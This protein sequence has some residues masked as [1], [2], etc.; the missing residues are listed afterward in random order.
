MWS[1]GCMPRKRKQN[2]QPCPWCAKRGLETIVRKARVTALERH[3]VK[4][5]AAYLMEQ[6]M[7][8]SDIPSREVLWQMVLSQGREVADLKA[9]VARLETKR[10][11]RAKKHISPRECWNRRKRTL[12]A[13]FNEF[14]ARKFDL[15][16]NPEIIS[17]ENCLT[18][19][20]VPVLEQRDGKLCLKNLDTTDI[21]C[22]AKQIW[23]KNNSGS[24]LV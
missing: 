19:V 1:I 16:F 21:Y 23:G 11:P 14:G 2:Y 5:K 4:C 15:W 9:R 20:L 24:S 8:S 3:M 6:P 22:L 12:L 18:A 10:V 17:V 13:I 7:V